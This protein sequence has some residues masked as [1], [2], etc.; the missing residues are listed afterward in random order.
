VAVRWP[1]AVVPVGALV[2]G[3]LLA[4][5]LV[6]A[7]AGALTGALAVLGLA[8]G[9]PVGVSVTAFAA[10]IARAE[11]AWVAPLRG[12]R[13]WDLARPV[14]V[15]FMP[16]QDWVARDDAWAAAGRIRSVSQDGRREIADL[17]VRAIVA[18]AGPPA[19]AGAYRLRGYLRAPLVFHN[20]EPPTRTGGWQIRVKSARM[21]S[22]VAAPRSRDVATRARSRLLA[23]LGAPDERGPGAALLEGLLLGRPAALP[24]DWQRGLRRTGLSHLFVVSGLHVSLIAGVVWAA[25]GMLRPTP[26][27]VCALAAAGAY[28][29]LVGLAPTVLRSMFMLVSMIAARIAKRAPSSLN[30]LAIAAGV[31][32]AVTP[33]LVY[34]LSFQLTVAATAGV[35]GLGPWL[36]RRWRSGPV[37]TAVAASLGAQIATLPLTAPAFSLVPLGGAALNL[38][39][40]P[41]T[42]GCLVLGLVWGLLALVHPSWGAW[43][44]PLFDPLAR[45]FGWLAALPPHPVVSSPIA[46][47]TVASCLLAA[48]ALAV[49]LRPRRLALAAPALLVFAAIAMARQRTDL[50]VVMLDVGQGDAILLRDGRRALLVDGG[51]WPA[52]DFG[53]RV[54]LPA[55][56]RL[57]VRALDAVVVSHPDADHCSG[58]ADLAAYLPVAEIWIAPGWGEAACVRRL[59]GGRGR[60]LRVWWQGDRIAWGRFRLAVLHPP[61]GETGAGNDRSLVLDASAGGRSLLLTGDIPERVETALVRRRVLE[62]VDALK[63]AHHGSASST[64]LPFLASTAPRWALVSAGRANGYG[65]PSEATLRRLGRRHAVVLRTDRHGWIR[66]SWRPS[67]PFRLTTGRVSLAA[68]TVGEWVKLGPPRLAL[69]D[70]AAP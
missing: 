24:E 10:G 21:V 8:L 43:W 48:A 65:H 59:V 32:V 11:A 52:G 39:A 18:S 46:I 2:A 34:D 62:A 68:E 3:A 51:G 26:R 54:L 37:A 17:P 20:G 40:V 45:P 16:D 57:G 36:A 47:G 13:G 25:A 58:L 67:G 50:E 42:G 7:P 60:R 69:E 64:S 23:G 19:A 6:F 14:T 15:V 28:S 31:L 49:A 56:A 61:P 30:A 4:P 44:A 33:A 66:M 5:R 55:L 22:A 29:L 70:L 63:I 35:V 41:W 1:P 53:G 9:G 27:A 12:S 38:V